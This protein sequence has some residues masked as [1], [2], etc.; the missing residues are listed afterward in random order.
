[1][2]ETNIKLVEAV[3]SVAR[4]IWFLAIVEFI[5]FIFAG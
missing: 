1:M 5:K 3:Y 2:A 4:A